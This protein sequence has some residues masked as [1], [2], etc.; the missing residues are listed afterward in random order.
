MI[1]SK[2]PLRVSFFG[3]SSDISHHYL[4]HTGATI[5]MA[6]DKYVYVSVMHTPYDHVKVS[7]SK[8][9]VWPTAED[10]KNEIVRETLLHFNI[11]SNIE[12]TTFADIPTIGT[13]LGGSSAF[14]CALVRAIGEFK[15]MKFNSYDVAELA[16]YIEIDRC[17]RNIGLQDQYASAFGGMN[18]IRYGVE[19]V[20]TQSVRNEVIV[21][22]MNP[23]NIDSF[24]VL[25]PTLLSRKSAHEIID[26]IDFK[27]NA[28]NINLLAAQARM[29]G[30]E[31]PDPHDYCVVLDEAWKIKKK[32]SKEITSTE[33]EDLLTRCSQAGAHGSKLLGAGGGGY[34][35]VITDDRDK[36][37]K[38]F[39][40]RKCLNVKVAEHGA[41]VVY[42][43]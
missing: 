15:G 25:V 3:G 38:E 7:Y 21:S 33:I 40:D 27:K 43:D 32:T 37:K 17:K 34:I 13:G 22:R 4:K 19:N 9:E 11:K 5:S 8:Q 30:Y 18:F 14:T 2:A 1:L 26:T 6:I 39:N 12:I 24:C 20:I 35:L 10:V 42:V 16:S 29:L 31:V 28:D 41:E 23:N 36:I